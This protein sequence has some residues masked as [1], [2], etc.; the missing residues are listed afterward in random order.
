MKIVHDLF[1]PSIDISEQ[2][3]TVLYVENQKCLSHLVHAHI[4]NDSSSL[5]YSNH[6]QVLS[7]GKQVILVIDIFNL[8]LNERNIKASFY[9]AVGNSIQQDYY[10]SFLR[11]QSSILEFFSQVSYEFDL[12][13]NQSDAIDI[14]DLIKLVNLELVVNNNSLLD[15][16]MDYIKALIWLT[17]C[18]LV[19]FVGLKQF[20]DSNQLEDFYKYCIDNRMHLL[21][22]E[23]HQYD[24]VKYEKT[25]TIDSDLCLI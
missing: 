14:K 21:L 16:L 10:E 8:I 25:Y 15:K 20:L 22:L 11:L 5:L 6:N 1:N 24:K 2:Y 17:D 7:I 12:D 3:V 4:D 13:I 19:V 23:S 9:K 18:Q